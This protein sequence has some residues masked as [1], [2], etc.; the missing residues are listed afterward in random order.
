[1]QLYLLFQEPIPNNQ[2]ESIT[3]FVVA[4][5]L[6]NGSFCGDSFGETDTRFSY[7]AI[8]TLYLLDRLDRIDCQNAIQYLKRCQNYD[9]GFALEPEGESHAGQVFCCVAALSLL[10]EHLHEEES[11]G[12]SK[13]DLFLS[14]AQLEQLSY[15]LSD[16]QDMKTGGLNGR[17]EKLPDVSFM[18][19]SLSW[20]LY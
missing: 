15:W 14:S 12:S 6:P 16:R 20:Q 13:S 3:T 18:L 5:Q 17:P 7:C 19:L 4:R 9:G 1:V 10:K 2:I 8:A 11:H